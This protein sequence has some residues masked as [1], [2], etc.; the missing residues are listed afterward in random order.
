MD[1]DSRSK[2]LNKVFN[3]VLHGTPLNKR[4]FSQFLEAIRTQADPAA[5]A[6][7]IVGSPYG[8]SSLCTAMRYDLSDVFLNNGAADTIAYLQAPNIEAV[9]GGNLLRQ[10][11]E[12]IVNP[13]IL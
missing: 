3:D 8:L 13:P 2:R 9:S 7:R 6:N 12:A 4:S 11:L 10:I 5:C 1:D